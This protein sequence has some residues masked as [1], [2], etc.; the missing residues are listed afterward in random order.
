VIRDCSRIG[1]SSRVDATA[2]RSKDARGAIRSR[3]VGVVTPIRV[4]S[5][6]REVLAYRPPWRLNSVRPWKR[7][8]FAVYPG[9]V[10]F[11][12]RGS[13]SR[14]S[15]AIGRIPMILSRSCTFRCTP[16]R[17]FNL[18]KKSVYRPRDDSSH[19]DACLKNRS[20]KPAAAAASVQP[21]ERTRVSTILLTSVGS[22]YES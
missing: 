2:C 1:E 21:R 12:I 7:V 8:S 16:G 22:T 15:R 10:L 13:I 4:T 14:G 19:S 17:V 18:H 20:M 5:P 11:S 6:G 9:D 3:F